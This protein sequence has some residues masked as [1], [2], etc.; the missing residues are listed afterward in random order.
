MALPPSDPR[1]VLGVPPGTGPEAVGRAFPRLLRQHHR[2]PVSPGSAV[3]RQHEKVLKAITGA[4]CGLA[5]RGT[6]RVQ[7]GLSPH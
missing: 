6:S 5:E 2:G 7:R 3:A 4:S 1:R